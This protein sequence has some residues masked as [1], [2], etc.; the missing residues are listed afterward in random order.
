[1]VE[2]SFNY[3]EIELIAYV[4]G[5]LS[6]ELAQKIADE[7]KLNLD[8]AEAVRFH[9]HLNMI[10]HYPTLLDD[11]ARF[12]AQQTPTKIWGLRKATF[13]KVAASLAFF[14][15]LGI[16][17]WVYTKAQTDAQNQKRTILV[18]QFLNV[19]SDRYVHGDLTTLD[20]GNLIQALTYY[21]QKEY[22]K[23]EKLLIPFQQYQDRREAGELG[24]YI[25]VCRLQTNRYESAKAILNQLLAENLKNKDPE[26]DSL[27]NA[28]YWHLALV[29]LAEG[30]IQTARRFLE[31]IPDTDDDYF[32]EAREMLKK[33]ERQ[34][35]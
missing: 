35:S 8:L 23:A 34:P 26:D 13:A 24:I 16:S 21:K 12:K 4:Q 27:L 18:K 33:I 2:K 30:D 22:W 14:S 19:K 32:K 11:L 25:A 29:A 20:D 5:T 17:T 3:S 1:M 31:A 15:L 6:V 7:I 10:Q 9:A 28:I